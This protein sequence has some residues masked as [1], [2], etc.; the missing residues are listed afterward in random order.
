MGSFCEDDIWPFVDEQLRVVRQGAGWNTAADS[1]CVALRTARPLFPAESSA[2]DPRTRDT[3]SRSS[4][5]VE[6]RLDQRGAFAPRDDN[7]EVVLDE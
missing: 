7:A 3:A 5:F 6:T 1:R 2:G 4:G